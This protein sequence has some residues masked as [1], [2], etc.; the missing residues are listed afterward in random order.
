VRDP[1]Y[2]QIAEGAPMIWGRHSTPTLEFVLIG[3]SAENL[4][5]MKA[6]KPLLIGPHDKDHLMAKVKIVVMVGETEKDMLT[7]LQ[8]LGLAD[9]N[10]S[11]ADL[12]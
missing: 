6:G 5:E 9:P 12:L 8:K 1:R 11:A 10:V 3:L 4:K 2:S 7:V